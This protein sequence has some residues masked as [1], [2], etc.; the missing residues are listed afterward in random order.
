MKL[1]NGSSIGISIQNT[2]EAKV[3]PKDST[4]TELQKIKLIDNLNIS[5]SYSMSAEEFKLSPIR[6]T[7]G[8]T[9]KDYFI[10]LFSF[11]LRISFN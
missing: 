11:K 1:A 3:K 8:F 4:Q 5:T 10:F 6:V 7:T 2:C 9:Y